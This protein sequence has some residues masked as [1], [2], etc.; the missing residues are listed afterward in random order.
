MKLRNPFTA[1]AILAFFILASVS[2]DSVPL[3][4]EWDCPA[5]LNTLE[6]AWVEV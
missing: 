2:A 3:H 1:K 6:G 5:F 4:A